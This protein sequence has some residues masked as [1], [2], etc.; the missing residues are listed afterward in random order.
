MIGLSDYYS[1]CSPLAAPASLDGWLGARR[2][3]HKATSGEK[4]SLFEH[5]PKE[6][7]HGAS[8]FWETFL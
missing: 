7:G 6:A 2:H 3:V 8:Q 5:V 4:P 1:F